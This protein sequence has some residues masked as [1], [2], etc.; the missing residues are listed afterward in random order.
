MLAMTDASE[1]LHLRVSRTIAE[2]IASGLLRSGDR[3]PPERVL[4]DRLGVS[5]VT[6][7]RG[8]TTLKADGLIQ[9]SAGRGWFVASPTL[10]EPPNALVSFTAMGAGRGLDAS[11]RVLAA[12]VRPATLDQAEA[13]EVPPGADIF[14]LERVRMLDGIPVALDRSRLP[15]ARAPGLIDVD[16]S[17]SSLYA[18]LESQGVVPTRATCAVEA[19]AADHRHGASLGIEAGTPLLVLRQTTF[20]QGGTPIELGCIV[21]PGDRYRFRALLVRPPELARSASFHSR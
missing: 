3:L 2:E 10:G 8:L 7:R 21:Y 19:T 20:D 4:C 14:D 6:L 17:T 11:S 16:F 9:S 5:R 15:L 18:T 12:T 13:L 1:S